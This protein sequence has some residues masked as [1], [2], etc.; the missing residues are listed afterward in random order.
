METQLKQKMRRTAIIHFLLSSVI[1]ALLV[2][3]SVTHPTSRLREFL[4]CAGAMMF[5]FLQPQFPILFAVAMFAVGSGWGRVEYTD[6]AV[7]FGLGNT[8]SGGWNS[9]P[10]Y[11][12]T[13]LPLS[14]PIWS[15]CYGWFV[16]NI[17]GR[18]LLSRE[19]QKPKSATPN[20]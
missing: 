16:A 13:F 3:D 4:F 11:G 19:P 1:F 9:A 2:S 17:A 8:K 14:I 18:S 6:P 10:C 12:L 15:L 20:P 7:W 5:C